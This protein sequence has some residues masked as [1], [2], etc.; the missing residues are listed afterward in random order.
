MDDLETEKKDNLSG[1][2]TEESQP[3]E[4]LKEQS[5][6]QAKEQS[7]NSSTNQHK[8]PSEIQ[9]AS[10]DINEGKKNREIIEFPSSDEETHE[11][12]PKRSGSKVVSTPQKKIEDLY[13][14][15]S[16]YYDIESD[17][18]DLDFNLDID[19]PPIAGITNKKKKNT[20]KGNIPTPKKPRKRKAKN[21]HDNLSDESGDEGNEEEKRQG[22]LQKE[23]QKRAKELEKEESKREKDEQ[24]RLRELEK[25]EQRKAKEHEKLEIEKDK[26]N[27]RKLKELQK[28]KLPEE[29]MPRMK[30]EYDTEIPVLKEAKGSDLFKLLRENHVNVVYVKQSVPGCMTWKQTIPPPVQGEPAE[31]KDENYVLYYEEASIFAN[32]VS[33]QNLDQKD[34]PLP[35]RETMKSIAEK[36]PG[37]KI[38]LLIEGLKMFFDHKKIELRQFFAGD[39]GIVSETM[40]KVKARIDRELIRFQASGHIK[41]VHS[42][43]LPD[44]AKGLY[45]ITEGIATAQEMSVL[46]LFS[47]FFVNPF[48]NDAGPQMT[49]SYWHKLIYGKPLD[50]KIITNI[51]LNAS[52]AYPRPQYRSLSK[53]IQLSDLL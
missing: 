32:L 34:T 25:E 46:F 35:L 51:N 22:Q 24:K 48:S 53:N 8:E 47:S 38:L 21:N 10:E 44:T 14:Y 23:E 19:L 7:E 45:I 27:K 30:L 12:P 15:D 43:N 40:I 3:K 17:S 18:Q 41:I 29:Y 50:S 13:E 28:G 2:E 1:S 36:Y 11:R 9:L 52:R 49:L 33:L 6:G 16:D 31:I 4:R 5:K 37:K 20:K 39:E 26:E 42:I